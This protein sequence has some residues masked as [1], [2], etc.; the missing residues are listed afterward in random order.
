MRNMNLHTLHVHHGLSMFLMGSVLFIFLVF[1][2]VVVVLFVFVLCL[3]H[4]V[5]RVSGL[6]ILK[7]PFEFL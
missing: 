3:V 6:L 7:R 2:V 5:A 1:C 4:N